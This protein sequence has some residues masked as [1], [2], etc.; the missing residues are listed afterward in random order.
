ML[1]LHLGLDRP[2]AQLIALVERVGG[3]GRPATL[4]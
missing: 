2:V 1:V 3:Y 4:H